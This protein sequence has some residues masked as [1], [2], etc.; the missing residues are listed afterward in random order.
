[1]SKDIEITNSWPLPKNGK[2]LP[3]DRTLVRVTYASLNPSDFKLPAIPIVGRYIHPKGIPGV[4]FAGTVVES[5]LPDF[6]RGDLVF[7]MT[8]PMTVGTLGKYVVIP[9]D[10]CVPVPDGLSLRRIFLTVKVRAL[11]RSLPSDISVL[12]QSHRLNPMIAD[13]DRRC[14][15][16]RRFP[17]IVVAA[18]IVSG[19]HE[20]VEAAP[21]VE[22]F[23]SG[24]TDHRTRDRLLQRALETPAD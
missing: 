24:N 4:D 16:T 3:K 7:G 15:E 6:T 10:C 21:A 12:L 22:A 13:Q 23:L 9:K 14:F 5:T 1:M 20:L 19:S 17:S 18:V 2:I 8:A 11:E